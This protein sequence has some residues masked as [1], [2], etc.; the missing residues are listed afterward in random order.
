MSEIVDNNDELDDNAVDN[1]LDSDG[2]DTENQADVDGEDN[3]FQHEKH[4]DYKVSDGKGAD[5]YHLSGMFRTWFLEYASYV[6]LERAIPHIND[7][8]KP[9]QRRVLYSMRRI[10][11]GRYNKVANIVGHTMQF[12][13]HGDASIGEA[14]VNLGQRN[15]LIDTQGNWGNILTGD[16]AAAPRYIEARLTKFALDA[17]FNPKTTEWKPSYD[18]RNK[19]PISLPVKFP[20]LLAQGSEGIGLG[21]NSKILPHNFG[22][23]CDASIAFL[24]DEDFSLFPD[25]PT[26]G[27][28]DVSKYNDGERGGKITIRAKIEKVDNKTLKIVEV[29]YGVTSGMLIESIVKAN[30]K[31]K[32]NI[33]KIEDITSKNVEIRLQLEAKTSSDKTIDALY[34]FTKCQVNYSPNCCVI[35]NNKP[36]FITVSE[37]LRRSTLTTKRLLKRELEIEK[38]ELLE[39]LHFCSLEK[40]F[41]QERI[42][43]DKEF[44]QAKSVD[45]ALS[46]IDKRLEPF[47]ANLVREVTIDDLKRLLEIKMARIL[48]FNLDKSEEQIL[49]LKDKIKAIDYNLDHLVEYTI[50]WFTYIKDKY[51]D[52]YPRQTELRNF[53]TIQAEKVVEA[54]KKLYFN[55]VEGFV[56]MA[57]K[58]DDNLQFVSNCSDIDDIIVF[59]K[60]G[61]YKVFK[62]ADKIYVGKDVIH[63]GVFIKNDKRT[64]YNAVYRNGASGSYYIKRFAVSSVTRDKD[65][66]LTQGAPGSKVVYFT[67]NANGE[68]EKIKVV[69]KPTSRVKNLVFEK[70]FSSIAIKGRQSIGNILT[71]FDVHKID[72]KQRGTSTLGGIDIYFDRD[73]LRLNVDKRGSLIGNFDGDDKIL[74]ITKSGDFY[75]TDF[76]LNN[77]YDDDLLLIEKFDPS[78]IWTAILYDAEQK[79]YYIKRFAFESINKRTQFISPSEGSFLKLI[80]DNYY[81]RFN[82]VFGNGDEFR[83]SLEIDADSFIGIKSF[84]AKGKRITSYNV[85]DIVELEPLRFPEDNGE[86]IDADADI[87]NGN[88]VQPDSNENNTSGKSYEELTKGIE[89]VT[90]QPFDD[91]DAD[92]SSKDI[93]DM[94]GQLRLF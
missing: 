60:D 16:S 22:E 92:D 49:A 52:K 65:Y 72:L 30:E 53:E 64:I 44:E 77:H 80:S 63:V 71:K 2:V 8:L 88:D 18:G 55:K 35:D 15:L 46:H 27:M 48:K 74:V 94:L 38:E 39:Q 37:V 25:F 51:A 56:G 50:N 78:K 69:L 90:N 28:L 10:E 33:K 45:I 11:D 41:I 36:C 91:E 86:N 66:D 21:L 47:K 17:V 34:A 75:V 61:K 3:N 87:D 1:V 79:Y 9:V 70:D 82:I 42:Y 58:R 59:H 68:A 83:G 40:I 29:P 20:L 32:V 57:L 14:L 19:E 24:R 62:V 76:D 54:N 73:V 6:N 31:G 13:P 89:I 12:H 81:S 67:A 23:L 43:K 5:V 4:S 93:D 85:A 26:G 84:K 7:G